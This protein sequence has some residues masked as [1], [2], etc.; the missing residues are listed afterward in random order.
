MSKKKKSRLGRGLGA[1][2]SDVRQTTAVASEEIV[3]PKSESEVDSDTVASVSESR[4]DRSGL[5]ELPI[6]WLQRGQFQPRL[7]MD[8]DALEE[9]AESIRAQGIIQPLLVRRLAGDK[10]EIIAGERRWR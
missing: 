9:L 5:R 4:P 10:F 8:K 2:L 3:P 1:L 7:N 6:E